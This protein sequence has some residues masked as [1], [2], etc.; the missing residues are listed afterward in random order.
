M[1]VQ[2]ILLS[3]LGAIFTSLLLL[4]VITSFYERKRRAAFKA[5]TLMLPFL[6]ITIV[7]YYLPASVNWIIASINA[8]FVVIGLYIFA[9]R[10]LFRKRKENQPEAAARTRQFFPGRPGQ[11]RRG[12]VAFPVR[13]GTLPPGPS[14]FPSRRRW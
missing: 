3:I 6:T 10:F 11:P 5:L 8:L 13:P 9:P 12:P 2:P 4:M 14:P 7:P 1:I